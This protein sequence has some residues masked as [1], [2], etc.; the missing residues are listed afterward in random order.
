MLEGQLHML[1]KKKKKTLVDSFVDQ[2]VELTESL[3]ESD[4]SLLTR[5]NNSTKKS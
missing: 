1:H 2:S 5:M 4:E 3:M